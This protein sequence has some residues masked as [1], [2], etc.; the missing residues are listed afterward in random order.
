M[1][2]NNGGQGVPQNYATAMQW[3]QKA[4]EQGD[5]YVQSL[6]GKV[7]ADGGMGVPQDYVQAIKWYIIAEANSS[8]RV[9]YGMF[10]EVQQLEGL[11]TLA[12]ITQAQKLADVWL[13]AHH[14]VNDRVNDN[15][16]IGSALDKMERKAINGDASALQQLE[17]TAN[18]GDVKAQLFLMYAYNG[19]GAVPQNHTI[20]AHWTEKAASQGDSYAQSE[21]GVWY[22]YGLGVPNDPVQAMQWFI[23]AKSNGD[24]YAAH[25]IQM[26][27]PPLPPAQI[28]EAQEL[29]GKWLAAHHRVK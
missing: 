15:R 14:R 19:V 23:I 1:I 2:Y 18:S 28:T 3:Y 13:A 4:A 7:Y 9:F 17:S 25:E 20:K 24:S 26:F 22:T 16:T 10:Y 27:Y 29:A 8:S 11:V 5:R 21:M 6:M 12:Q